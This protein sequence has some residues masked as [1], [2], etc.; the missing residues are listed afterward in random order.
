MTEAGLW[1]RPWYFAR[2]GETLADAYVRRLRQH[3]KK[4][5]CVM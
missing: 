1:Q 4:L 5:A 2:E 3:E